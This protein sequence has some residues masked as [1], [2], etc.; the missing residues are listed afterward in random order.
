VN[1][2]ISSVV[3]SYTGLNAKLYVNSCEKA[4]L[5]VRCIYPSYFVWK[6]PSGYLNT[7][8]T[9]HIDTGY[10]WTHSGYYFE[11]SWQHSHLDATN[12]TL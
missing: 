1:D 9:L 6:F 2:V 4:Q 12:C 11:V 5:S 7:Y 3:S 8:R 10:F